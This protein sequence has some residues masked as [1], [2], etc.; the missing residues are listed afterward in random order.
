MFEPDR[1][2][3]PKTERG[4]T[5]AIALAFC[6]LLLYYKTQA[7]PTASS[8]SLSAFDA[9]SQQYEA[10]FPIYRLNPSLR[11]QLDFSVQVPRYTSSLA[12]LQSSMTVTNL[13]TDLLNIVVIA[14][15]TTLKD[16]EAAG[17]D[18]PTV[19]IYQ[20]ACNNS[21]GVDNYN[22]AI[23]Y[24]LLAPQ[25]RFTQLVCFH[26][27]GAM[28]GE[29]IALTFTGQIQRFKSGSSVEQTEQT[30]QP[31]EIVL[32][33]SNAPQSL[34]DSTRALVLSIMRIVLLPPWANGFIPLLA[35]LMAYLID[36]H[37]AGLEEWVSKGRLGASR[38]LIGLGFGIVGFFIMLTIGRSLILESSRWAIC[39]LE[40]EPSTLCISPSG[41]E[42]PLAIAAR[43]ERRLWCGLIFLGLMGMLHWPEGRMGVD[44]HVPYRQSGPF[45]RLTRRLRQR[46][47]GNPPNTT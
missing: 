28:Q 17:Q 23:S 39:K 22:S 8:A 12:E 3:F 44:V 41:G 38:F 5:I 13:G 40:S 6:L 24:G 25:A 14:D 33:I 9:L 45:D 20:G 46:S 35:L 43:A 26:L 36:Q 42:E 18:D 7:L 10:N 29:K 19:I 15:A 31:E 30:E 47:G 16:S 37:L 1:L 21:V 4:W 32:A 34:V 11:Q 2:P 27:K